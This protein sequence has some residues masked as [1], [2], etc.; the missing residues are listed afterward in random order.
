MRTELGG[1]TKWVAKIGVKGG[2]QQTGERLTHFL[3][4]NL[5]LFCVLF[6]DEN[7]AGNLN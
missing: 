3:H 6:K 4:V 1:W 5:I 7:R 2:S